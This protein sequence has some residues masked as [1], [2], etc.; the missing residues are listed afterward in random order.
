MSDNGVTE[1]VDPTQETSGTEA[2][3]QDTTAR[4]SRAALLEE[5]GD[6]A[7]DYLEELLDLADIDGDIDID[8]VDGRA[9]VAVVCEDEDSNLGTLV[10]RDGAV[11]S[12][13]QELTRLAVQARTG[14]RSWLVL[15][16]DGFRDRRKDD[17]RETARKA[18]E[19]V[20][21]TGERYEFRP[22]NAFERKVVHDQV[23]K[24]GLTSESE[25]EGDH[26]RVVIVP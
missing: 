22:M 16:V 26:R 18:I 15:D 2:D 3:T 4:P 8:V 7:A 20:Q 6:I 14:Q 1:D 21:E 25:G 13:L 5:E 23:A 24:A 19:K 9:Q 11:L 12:S 17:L 10:G